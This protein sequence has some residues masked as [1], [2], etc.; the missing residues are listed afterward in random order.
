M[1]AVLSYPK[2]GNTWCRYIIEALTKR[3]TIGGGERGIGLPIGASFPDLNVDL[4]AKPVAVKRHLLNLEPLEERRAILLLRNPTEIVTDN[5]KGGIEIYGHL[6][7]E[8][9][10]ADELLVI[11][12]EEMITSDEVI[13]KIGNFCDVEE[14]SLNHIEFHRQRC[15][16][17]Y[18]KQWK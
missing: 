17:W 10:K 5:S 2:S 14:P 12:F 18:H 13:T 16:N 7:K 8:A 6:M 1:I 9:A 3:P 15:Y 4:T 11:G